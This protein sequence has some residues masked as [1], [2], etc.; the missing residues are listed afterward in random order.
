MQINKFNHLWIVM[1]FFCLILVA[2]QAP[3]EENVL[4][5]TAALE[6]AYP[7]EEVSIQEIPELETAYPIEEAP[8]QLTPELDAAYPITEDDLQLLLKTWE[9]SAFSEVGV[10]QDRR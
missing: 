9:L 3:V 4:Q 2:C 10:F 6:T 7:A 1:A 8:V 5:E